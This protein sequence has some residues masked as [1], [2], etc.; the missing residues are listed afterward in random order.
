MAPVVGRA[1]PSVDE[2]RAVA[3]LYRGEVLAASANGW[4]IGGNE[5]HVLLDATFQV[6]GEPRRL[7]VA[8]RDAAGGEPGAA[9]GAVLYGLRGEEW[10]TLAIEPELFRTRA[11][12]RRSV[13]RLQ[14]LAARQRG[15]LVQSSSAFPGGAGSF[16]TLALARDDGFAVLLTIVTDYRAAGS[17]GTA[18]RGCEP[19]APR[20]LPC[21]RHASLAFVR[22]ERELDDLELELK[23]TVGELAVPLPTRRLRYVYD[24]DRYTPDVADA[25]D[26]AAAI[27]RGFADWVEGRAKLLVAGRPAAVR[28]ASSLG[29]VALGVRVSGEWA[30]ADAVPIET[31][32]RGGSGRIPV[33]LARQNGAWAI[34]A[35]GEHASP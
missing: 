23:G 28:P 35:L 6:S 10:A 20:S 3:D 19:E 32:A 27:E 8:E 18:F 31:A 15:F 14:R 17:A 22:G 24:G 21:T 30:T 34:A 11:G 5:T 26:V 25:A 29:Y 2:A 4:R 7:Y 1:Q 9:I 13:A 12:S 16:A 33:R